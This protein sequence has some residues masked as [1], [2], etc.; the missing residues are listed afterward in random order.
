MLNLGSTDFY[1]AV[2]SLPREE[3]EAYSSKLFDTW[4][5]QIAQ[6]LPLD[7]YA[8]S[9]EIEEGSIQGSGKVMARLIAVGLFISHYGSIVQGLQTMR[10][11]LTMA[12]NYLT[13]KAHEFLGSEK[14][15]PTVKNRSGTLGQI[16]RLFIKV[17]RQEM[18]AE[19]AMTE[20]EKILGKEAAS[21]PD[22]MQRLNA[23]LLEAPVQAQ[24]LFLSPDGDLAEPAE[25][26]PTKRSGP[27][28]S[29]HVPVIPEMN[30]FRVE[31]WRESKRGKKQIRITAI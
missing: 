19:E 23:A 10:S 30:Q 14:P 18:T 4:E 3:L 5:T 9:L 22:F 29:N 25:G 31:V 8:L 21:A 16:Q 2:P 11:H 6:E 15:A 17:Q 1:F 12:G 20:A 26:E 27:R 24:Q 13:E 28:P 7:D